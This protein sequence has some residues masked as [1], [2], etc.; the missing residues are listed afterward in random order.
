MSNNALGATSGSDLGFWLGKT[1]DATTGD[2]AKLVGD[3]AKGNA[4]VSADLAG[5]VGLGIVP[6]GAQIAAGIGG[7]ANT[8]IQSAVNGEVNYTDVLIASWVGVVTSNT[9]LLGTVGWNAAGGAMSNYIKGDDPLTGAVISGGASGIGYGVGK[10]IQGPLDKVLNPNWKNWEWVDLGMGISKPLP[11]NPAPGVIGNIFGSG[12]SEV[13]NE[14][15][16][17]EIKKQGENK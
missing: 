17:K 1:P 11:L 13:T 3:I 16:G 2:K 8:L 6:G 15:I 5:T 12:A 7:G 10:V 14:K 9:G 4:I